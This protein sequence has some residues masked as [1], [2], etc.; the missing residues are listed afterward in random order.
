MHAPKLSGQGDWYLKRQLNYFKNGARGAHDKDV[1]GKQM[2]PMAATLSDDAAINNVV[3]YIKTLP[4]NPV[5]ATVEGECQRRSKA[6]CDLRSL[7]RF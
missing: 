4:D 5:Q 3:A 2:A 1:Y 6:I 7:S